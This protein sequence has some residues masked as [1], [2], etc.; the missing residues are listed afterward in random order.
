MDRIQLELYII[1]Q[2]RWNK[3][4][5]YHFLSRTTHSQENE[6]ICPQCIG[7]SMY[8][9][10]TQNHFKIEWKHTFMI[11]FYLIEFMIFLKCNTTTM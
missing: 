9:D 11:E 3:R 2:Y 6:N 1:G 10:N 7:C 8:D 5:E 4:Q